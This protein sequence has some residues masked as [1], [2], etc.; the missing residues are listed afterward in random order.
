MSRSRDAARAKYKKG[1]LTVKLP[2]TEEAKS[3]VRKIPIKA[4]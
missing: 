1:V 3:N 2:R 4:D